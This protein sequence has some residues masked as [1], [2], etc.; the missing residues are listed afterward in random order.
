MTAFHHTQSYCCD[1]Q[2]Q[3]P[4]DLRAED[5]AV[6]FDVHCPGSPKSLRVSS[7]EAIFR[8]LRAKSA[9]PAEV[10]P[11]ARGFSW[12]NFIEITKDCNCTCAICFSDSSPGAGGELTLEQV[13]TLARG[14]RNQGLKAVTLSGGEPTLHPRLLDIVRAIRGLGMD[15]T[16]ATN[17]L[18]LA[19]DPMLAQQLRKAGVTYLYVQMD[20]LVGETCRI[21]RGDDYVESKKQAIANARAA[22]LRFGLTTTMIRDNLAEVGDVLRFASQHL[23]HLGVIGYLSA[24]PAGRFTLPEASTVNREDII[25][26]LIRSGAVAGLRAEHFW[27]FPRFSPFAL[28]VHPDC[29]ALLFL[30]GTP[31]GLRPLD[32]FVDIGRLYR[33]MRRS[34]A[35]FNRVWGLLLLSLCFLLSI[36][37]ARAISVLRMVLGMLT[38]R[39]RHALMVLSVEQFLGRYYQDRERLDRCTTCN[40]R[41][42]GSRVSTCIFEHP[43]PR[44]SPATRAREMG[45]S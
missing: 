42:D 21:M 20:T 1:C 30:G 25:A 23:P 7:D 17:G 44:R 41:P 12:A 22:G 40:I 34:R 28:D 27:P 5:G 45:K 19:R 24:A 39:G 31:T 16:L 11:S 10:L 43:D 18:K 3:H 32:E 9:L 33:L 37:P 4:A 38:K 29:A 2:D 14:L 8:G 35:R 6:F 26:A 13:V 36:R 15:V